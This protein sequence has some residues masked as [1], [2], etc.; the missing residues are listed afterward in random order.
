MH[1]RIQAI[2][3]HY[4]DDPSW[5]RIA[6]RQ[7]SST[8]AG[9]LGTGASGSDRARWSVRCPAGP[10]LCRHHLYAARA[11]ADSRVL[12]L[13]TET[14]ESG[15]GPTRHLVGP[16]PRGATVL[17]G[18]VPGQRGAYPCEAVADPVTRR[19]LDVLRPF[20]EHRLFDPFALCRRCRSESADRR[21]VFWP[22]LG[23]LLIRI[24]NRLG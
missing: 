9:L 11:S 8:V 18:T 4:G 14:A 13:T 6:S 19:R 12:S 17:H 5:M 3:D 10:R 20:G 22:V 1:V 2:R 16:T 23:L 15:R 21:L 7:A 24:G